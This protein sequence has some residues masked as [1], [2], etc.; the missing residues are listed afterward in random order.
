MLQTQDN[1]LGNSEEF[2]WIDGKEYHRSFVLIAA[3]FFEIILRHAVFSFGMNFREMNVDVLRQSPRVQNHCDA[4]V[5][6]NIGKQYQRQQFGA[7]SL[8]L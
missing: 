4:A 8:F 2:V 1:I 3:G 7:Q 5:A 6:Q